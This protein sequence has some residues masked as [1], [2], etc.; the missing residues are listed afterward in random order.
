M[1][2]I[3]PSYKYNKWL[4]HLENVIVTPLAAGSSSVEELLPRTT[5]IKLCQVLESE[6][7]QSAYDDD[8]EIITNDAYQ[9]LVH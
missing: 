9:S 5:S 6:F 4:I 8:I 3:T 1:M 2:N 7:F